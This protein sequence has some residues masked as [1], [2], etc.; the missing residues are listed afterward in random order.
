MTSFFRVAWLVM[1]KDLRVESRS[2][3]MLY[4][5]LFFAASCVLVFSFAFVGGGRP[6]EGA[7][8][9]ILWIAV[10]FSGTLALA[11]AFER[12]RPR[13]AQRPIARAH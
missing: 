12:E 8:A 7:A 2:R 13:R 5:T 4:T 10:A 11:R 6:V 1:R 3:E 9:G